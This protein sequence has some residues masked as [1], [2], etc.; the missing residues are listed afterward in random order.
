MKIGLRIPGTARAL[1]FGEFCRWCADNGFE[2]VDIG[3]VTPDIVKTARDAGLVI[4]SAD[5]AGTRDLLSVDKSKQEAGAEAAKAAIQAAA[6]NDVHIMFCVFAPEDPSLGRAKTFDLWK[7]TV[8]PIAEFAADRGVSI[9]VEGWPGPAPYYPSLGCT[10]ETLRAMF[11]ACPKGLA[12]NYD[13]SHMVRIGV[14]YLRTLNEFAAYV[15]HVHGKDTVFD[16]EALYLHGNLGPSFHTPR[17]FGEDWWRYTIP[18]DGVVD[19]L[20]VVQ[21]L[22]DEGFDGIVSVELEDYR[23]WKTWDAEAEGLKRSR[24]YLARY[25]R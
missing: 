3:E 4:G 11:A 8:P 24:E 14:D 16:Q 13:P 6:D 1:P 12:L 19:W 20:K 21:R 5:L 9:A 17:G 25:V 23:Y 15:R 2:A 7:E 10:P 18:G 22:E